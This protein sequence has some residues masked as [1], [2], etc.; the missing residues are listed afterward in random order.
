ME[1]Y[2]EQ[3]YY[4]SARVRLAVRF[5]NPSRKRFN[6]NF[7]RSP[8]TAL[9]RKL[10]RVLDIVEDDGSL[11]LV[12]RG[13]RDL[14]IS[15]QRQDVSDDELTQVIDGVIPLTATLSLNGLRTAST[16]SM[17]IPYADLPV[18]PRMV[19]GIGVEFYLGTVTPEEFAAGISGQ[20]RREGAG[21]VPLNVIPFEYVD[22][23]GRQRTNL[24]FEGWVDSWE[25]SHGDGAPTVKLECR[26]NT[27]LLIDTEAPQR[28]ALDPRLPITRAI[29]E[30]LAVF[31][32]F[33]GLRVK[34]LPT[35]AEVPVYQR[36]LQKTAFQP[37]LGPMVTGERMSVWDYFTDVA[38]AIGHTVRF[39]GKTIVVQ[40]PRTYFGGEFPP[41]ED[42]PFRGRLL[43]S[44]REVPFRLFVYG[45]NVLDFSMK[46]NFTTA[47]PTT[48][49]VRCYSNTKKKTLVVRY[50][51]KKDRLER[52][53]PGSLLPDEK[54]VV[55]RLSGIGDQASLQATAQ[56]IYEQLGRNEIEVTLRTTNLG[57]F[58]GSLFDP[59]LLDCK[60]GDTI[61]LEVTA[62]GD[63]ASVDTTAEVEELGAV[64]SRAAEHLRRLGYRDDFA[65]AYG[66]AKE[67]AKRQPFFR[68]KRIEYQWDVEKG[69]DISVTAVNYLEVRGDRL[70]G[71][72]EPQETAQSIRER[73]LRQA[74]E[75]SVVGQVARR[76]GR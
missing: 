75:F 20:T 38:G 42:D 1:E 7:P 68:V 30:Y 34:Y 59:D 50:P 62:D 60:P 3:S 25:V 66:L 19:R 43:P 65:V 76:G 57:S 70:P 45:R 23:Y 44:G 21:E 56:Q 40:R 58:G 74:R 72:A 64:A 53:L 36:V 54:I 6:R 13:T 41:R 47:A 28:L 49:E 37:R 17:E 69:V 33:F 51:L 9:S 2:P 10:P 16:L 24:R 61:Q 29:A 14:S 11:V 22:G 67:A 8:V 18:E 26:D 12:P 15:P 4:P 73:Q 52:G 63:T 5:D 71:E 31:P 55:F 35:G 48:I 46:R 27:T 32:Q 39:D